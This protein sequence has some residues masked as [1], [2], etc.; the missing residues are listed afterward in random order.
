MNGV[1]VFFSGVYLFNAMFINLIG[2]SFILLTIIYI[3]C[4]FEVEF[5]SEVIKKFIK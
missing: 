1:S 5:M 3:G 4:V 2:F